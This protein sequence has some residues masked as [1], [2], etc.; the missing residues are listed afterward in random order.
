MGKRP[1]FIASD[2]APWPHTTCDKCGLHIQLVQDGQMYWN[3][4]ANANHR[5]ICRN[6]YE[7]W[8]QKREEGHRRWRAAYEEL[9]AKKEPSCGESTD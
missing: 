3:P 4:N 8:N 5:N 9:A 2:L 1:F 6:C 7:V